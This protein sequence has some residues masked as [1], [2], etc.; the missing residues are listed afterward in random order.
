MRR[1]HHHAALTL[2]A[3]NSSKSDADTA[4][5][6]TSEMRRSWS[7]RGKRKP[8]LQR[9]TVVRSTPT[10]APNAS[11]EISC[12]DSQS[13]SFMARNVPY[14]HKRGNPVCER[15][16]EDR[17]PAL[18]KHGQMDNRLRELRQKKRLTLEKVAE[19]LECDHSTVSRW[20][21]G[22]TPPATWL[23]KLATFYGVTPP[24][25]FRAP[26]PRDDADV[27]YEQLRESVP[28]PQLLAALNGLRAVAT[29]PESAPAPAEEQ[30]RRRAP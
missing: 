11:S 5:A 26:K 3:D 25:L 23:D 27:T 24:E 21:N 6:V 8:R 15:A 10:S 16:A 17:L 20:E 28:L 18:C 13:S 7:G 4:P 12:S 22:R 2:V 19:A 14:A 9:L 1:N 29:S 30:A